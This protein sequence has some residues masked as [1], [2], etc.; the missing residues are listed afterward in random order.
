MKDGSD[1]SNVPWWSP[2]GNLLYWLMNRDGFVCIWARRLDPS[3]KAPKGDAFAV[4]HLHEARRSLA[5]TGSGGFSPALSRDK[6]ILNLPEDSSNIWLAEP[7]SA[8]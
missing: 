8:K 7:E 5:G 6:L 1:D 3:T 4:L 2:D